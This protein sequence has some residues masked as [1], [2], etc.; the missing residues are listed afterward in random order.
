MDD[1]KLC[2]ISIGLVILV[3]AGLA[4][5]TY[6]DE[7]GWPWEKEEDE[8][9]I[10]LIQEGDEI[11]VDYVGRF[12]GTA[13][14]PGAVFDTSIPEIARN[15]SIPK[16]KGFTARS[17]YDDLTFKVGDGQ[18]IQGFDEAVLGKKEGQT[19]TVAIPPAKGYGD[20]HDELILTVNST[21]TM[22]LKETLDR[23]RFEMLYPA[24]DLERVSTFTHPFW[25][26]DVSVV[27][28]DIEEVQIWHQPLYSHKYKGFP[29]NVTVVDISTER[30]VI[31]LYHNIDEIQ[32][33]TKVTFESAQLY[34]PYWAEEAL[35]LDQPEPPV[36]AWVT[37]VGG[38][39]TIDFNKEVAGRLLVF[40]ITI[41]SI[42]R[43]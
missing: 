24:V 35:G 20:A 15:T 18:M 19:F 4:G 12:V 42:T 11:S 22:T 39:I 34:D 8:K 1:E 31:T 2:L 37:S 10:L 36:E 14:E 23:A 13:G 21:Q 41:N 25:G 17:T 32:K 3:F 28:F 43:E 16:S 6:I 33:T 7:E 9:E 27:S 40:T 38:A 29:W 26:W 5:M 30:N